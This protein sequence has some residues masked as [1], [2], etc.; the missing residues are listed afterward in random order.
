MKISA[1]LFIK[2][3]LVHTTFLSLLHLG[4]SS[5]HFPANP[6]ETLPVQDGSSLEALDPNTRP[7]F[8][9]KPETQMCHFSHESL[10]RHRALKEQMNSFQP[11]RW[12]KSCSLH[13]FYDQSL[14]KCLSFILLLIIVHLPV[15]V[16]EGLAIHAVD[17]QDAI[18]VVHFVLDDACWP[19]AGLPQD[20]FTF[21]IQTC[22]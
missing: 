6:P 20:R 16:D 18:Q 8:K 17:V 12:K 2:Y 21:F 10:R 15:D 1:S 19:A 11:R 4:V 5:L 22:R 3:L 9:P 14:C 7:L 13:Q